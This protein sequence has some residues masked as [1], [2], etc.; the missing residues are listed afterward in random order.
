MFNVSVKL[1]ESFCGQTC[2]KLMSLMFSVF[3]AG[4]LSYMGGL[5]NQRSQATITAQVKQTHTHACTFKLNVCFPLA[6]PFAQPVQAGLSRLYAT[7]P[8]GIKS[9]K[10]EWDGWA[11]QLAANSKK[12]KSN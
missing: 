3:A 11:Q 8:F 10:V 5:C 2:V 4:Q 1:S 12:K 7:S 6:A 9:T